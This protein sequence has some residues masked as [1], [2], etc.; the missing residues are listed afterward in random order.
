M[1]GEG[2]RPN[3]VT[4]IGLLSGLCMLDQLECVHG[5]AVRYGLIADLVLANSMVNV[6]GRMER[7]DL[8]RALFDEMGLKDR[9]SWNSMIV[10]YSRV[11][12]TR[13]CVELFRGMIVSGECP[14]QQTYG[15]LLSSITSHEGALC[16]LGKSVHALVVTSGFQFD[17]QI[18]TGLASFHLKFGRHDDAFLVFDRALYRDVVSWTAMISGL[19]QN[20]GADKALV[21]FHRMLRSG[22]MPATMTIAS[23]L[24]ACAQLSLFAL[25]SSIH[26]FA[27]RRRM[28]LDVAARN[29]LT[30]MYAKCGHLRRCLLVFE[31]MEDRDLVS[32]NAVVSGCAQSG[33]LEQAFSLFRRMRLAYQRPDTITMVSLLQSCASRGALVHGRLIHGFMIRHDLKKHFIALDTSLVDMYSKCGALKTA[34]TCFALM[35]EHD[36][37]SWSA[38]I[39]GYGSHGMGEAALG[40]YLGFLRAG[41]VPNDVMFMS[42]LSACSHSGLVSQGLAVFKSMQ[43]FGVTPRVEHCACVVDLLSKAGRLEE[44]MGFIRTMPAEGNAD[45]WGMLLDVCRANG[46]DNLAEVVAREIVALRPETAGSYVQLARGYAAMNR[47]DGVGE[48]WVQMR[49]LGLRKTPGWSFIQLNGIITTFFAD[50]TS[51]PRYAEM[52][53]LLKVLRSEMREVDG[54]FCG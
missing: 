38:I 24:S 3:S 48:A 30:T 10:G 49:R 11:G 16:R 33:H 45:V 37:V 1:L 53:F 5:S 52:I 13:E 21:V 42:V 22:V 35:P 7:L 54:E 9:V 29:S 43:E 14:D 23:I 12:R 39:A 46:H 40:M 31:A 51:H 41:M 6:Y 15:S 26:G 28:L 32:W 34:Q 18:E 17:N 19:V 47:W 8:A 44:A 36:L 2:I 20:D 25:G 27:I 50:S 4:L